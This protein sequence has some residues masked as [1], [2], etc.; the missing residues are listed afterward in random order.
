MRADLTVAMRS[1]DRDTVRVLRS[2]LAAIANAE[3]QPSDDSEPTAPRSAGGIAGASSGLGATDVPR[4][5]LTVDDVHGIVADERRERL[6]SAHDLA[7]RGAAEPAAA[8]RAE[9]AILDG[10]LLDLNRG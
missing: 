10:Y 2:T 3:A 5:V 6:D 8:L 7:E 4:R 1:R 9:A